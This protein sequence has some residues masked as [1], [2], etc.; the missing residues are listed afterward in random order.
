MT[1]AD[2]A[3]YINEGAN[4]DAGKEKMKA[5]KAELTPEEVTDLVAYIR[6]FKA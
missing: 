2:M 5:F 3:K 6:K 4:D 1:D